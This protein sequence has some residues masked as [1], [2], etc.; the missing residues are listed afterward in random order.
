MLFVKFFFFP[1]PRPRRL[2]IPGGQLP[3]VFVVRS[4]EDANA[5]A[6]AAAQKRVVVV[7][8][9]FIGVSYFPDK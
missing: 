2:D 8:T 9:S 5:V 6:A 1:P 7:G 3:E 4:P